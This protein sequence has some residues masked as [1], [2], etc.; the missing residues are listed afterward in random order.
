MKQQAEK[1]PSTLQSL[2]TLLPSESQLSPQALC[3]LKGGDG[4]TLPPP[5]I[6]IVDDVV[7]GRP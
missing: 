4:E 7:P 6:I 5:P 1:K 2:A 3:M